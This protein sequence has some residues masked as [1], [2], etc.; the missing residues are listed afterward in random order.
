[1]LIIR[2]QHTYIIIDK[3]N[4]K[5]KS[6]DEYRSNILIDNVEASR[7]NVV[8]GEKNMSSRVNTLLKKLIFLLLVQNLEGNRFRRHALPITGAHRCSG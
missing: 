2:M 3:L 6:D 7:V 4:Y 1:M 5:I 8:D